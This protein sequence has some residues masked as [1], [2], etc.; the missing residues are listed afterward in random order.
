MDTQTLVAI[1]ALIVGI[2]GFL[3]G[4]YQQFANR[5]ISNIAYKVTQLTDFDLPD[6][7][8]L[9]L[10]IIPVTIDVESVGNKKAENINIRIVTAS[11]ITNLEIE[12]GE[13]FEKEQD[14]QHLRI[15]IPSCNPGESIKISAQCAKAPSLKNY[16]SEIS[17]THSEG[18]G[19]DRKN[20]PINEIEIELPILFWRAR[21]IYNFEKR[22]FQ[23]R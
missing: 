2:L 20:I 22:T 8:L 11:D 18:V 21:L 6:K 13:P 14:A 19:V 16:I 12:S 1:G 23:I 4:I 5:R 15:R 7:F 10:S 9:P 3:F 17:V